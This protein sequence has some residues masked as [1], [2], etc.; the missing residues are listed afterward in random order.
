[1]Q[2]QLLPQFEVHV[3]VQYVEQ[4]SRPE[5]DYY[6]FAYHITITNHGTNTAQLISRH[7]IITDG[8]GQTEEARGA[9]VVGLQPKIQPGQSFQYDSACPLST[10]HGS[11]KGSF[12]MQG[13]DGEGFEIEIAEFYLIAPSSLH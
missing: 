10:P 6:F 1:M 12:Q 8:E 5:A 9:G 7:W 11:M 4:E 2:R 13:D 3:K